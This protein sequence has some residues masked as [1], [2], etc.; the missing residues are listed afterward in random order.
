MVRKPSTE[1]H[2]DPCQRMTLAKLCN[3]SEPRSWRL[4]DDYADL[5][6]WLEDSD[7]WRMAP[8]RWQLLQSV[9]PSWPL[10][11][12]CPARRRTGPFL[13]LLLTAPLPSLGC[14]ETPSEVCKHCC[15]LRSP[16]RTS[17]QDP[18]SPTLTLVCL[19]WPVPGGQDFPKH[20][21]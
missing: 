9:F 5:P 12:L 18:P 17:P 6:V 8:R 7:A 13:I 1:G 11:Q 16:L 20:S 2:R 21:S 14:S 19:V 10:G 4:G 15:C 3:I